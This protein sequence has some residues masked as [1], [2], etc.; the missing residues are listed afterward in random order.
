MANESL[1]VSHLVDYTPD[2][3]DP[4][5]DGKV[6]TRLLA[7]ALLALGTKID[8]LTAKLNADAGVTDTNY[9]T[10]FNATIAATEYTES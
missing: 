10:N 8:V 6:A 3:D 2:S 4:E 7:K 1:K 9:A 5:F